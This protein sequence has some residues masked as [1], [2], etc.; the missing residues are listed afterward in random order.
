MKKMR[1]HFSV[2]HA[3]KIRTP[4]ITEKGKKADKDFL[5][6]SGNMFPYYFRNLFPYLTS[7]RRSAR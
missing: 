6:L 1:P 3:C 7:T 2:L 4:Q 5:F